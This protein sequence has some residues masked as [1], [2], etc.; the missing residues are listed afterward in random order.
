MGDGYDAGLS[1]EDL[2]ECLRVFLCA[3][4]CDDPVP[5]VPLQ[6][7][8]PPPAQ[9]IGIEGLIDLSGGNLIVADEGTPITLNA[10]AGGDADAAN[11]YEHSTGVTI[12]TGTAN[13]GVI[14]PNSNV[15][16]GVIV[17]NS[18]VDSGVIVPNSSVDSAA[19]AVTHGTEGSSYEVVPALSV[20]VEVVPPAEEV[21][22]AAARAYI[23]RR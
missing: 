22:V 13:S 8:A 17:P 12:V 9:D 10:E 11:T 6:N 3:V 21:E 5:V 1:D 14:V 15:D 18:N 20:T 7:A 2:V 4:D 23:P 16:S 19:K